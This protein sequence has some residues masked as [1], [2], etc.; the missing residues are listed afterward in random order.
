MAGVEVRVVDP[1]NTSRECSECHHVA[2]TNRKTQARFVCGNCEHEENADTNASKN[3]ASR[4]PVNAPIVSLRACNAIKYLL[5]TYENLPMHASQN[6]PENFI[7]FKALST[8][9][10]AA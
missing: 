6:R 5:E 1:R 2:K 4:A 7:V 9:R 8:G 10:P 3:I